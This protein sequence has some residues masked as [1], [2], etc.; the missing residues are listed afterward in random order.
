[1]AYNRQT[2]M[3]YRIQRARETAKEAKEAIE[4][5]HSQLA[6][7]R[8]YYAMFYMVQALA[9]K[10]HFSSSKHTQLLG[11]FNKEFIHPGLIE[12]GLGKA[13]QAAFEKRQRG[14][15]DDFVTFLQEELENDYSNMS[16]FLD[17][18]EAII[19]KTYSADD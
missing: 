13:F 6:E 11:W 12:S 15:Y 4:R 18:V 10:Y 14:D 3:T 5:H 16:R 7:N 9:I 2:L 19:H 1:M 17:A 8:I